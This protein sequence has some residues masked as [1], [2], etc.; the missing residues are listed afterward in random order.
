[1]AAWA[2]WSEDISTKAKPFDRPV[3]RS[4]M[5]WADRTVPCCPNRADTSE[6]VA[7]NVRLPT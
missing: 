3:S 5:T 1:M 7:P 2:S 4:M 6:S